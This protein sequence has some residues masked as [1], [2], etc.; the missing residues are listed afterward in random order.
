MGYQTL[1]DLATLVYIVY[2]EVKHKRSLN[3]IWERFV[4]H[5]QTKR[6]VIN[7]Q[8]EKTTNIKHIEEKEKN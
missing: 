3:Y 4:E 5:L 7:H 2:V 1:I 6:L 8:E